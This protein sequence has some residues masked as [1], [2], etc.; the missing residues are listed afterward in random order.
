MYQP[1]LSSM[2]AF[3]VLVLVTLGLSG[4]TAQKMISGTI[5]DAA[6]NE[7]LIGANVVIKGTTTGTVTDFEGKFSLKA[8]EGDQLEISYTGYK[9][10]TLT[11]SS[12]DTYSLGLAAGELLSDVVVVGYGSVRKSDLTGSVVAV[13]E[14]DF[15]RGTYTSPE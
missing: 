13:G 2:R 10:V 4:L 12:E 15:N 9:T 5:T 7:P 8:N 6:T 11:V 14:K 3:F 1:L